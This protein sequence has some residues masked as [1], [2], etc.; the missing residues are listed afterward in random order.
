[1]PNLLGSG[2]AYTKYPFR[3]IKEFRTYEK[4]AREA[5]QGLWN[6]EK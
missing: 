2:F 5:Q 1:M 6:Q 4:Q 3:Y